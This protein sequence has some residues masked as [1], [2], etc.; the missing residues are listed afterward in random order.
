MRSKHQSRECGSVRVN[1]NSFIISSIQR[2]ETD[3]TPTAQDDVVHELIL[4]RG[5]KF[6]VGST[7]FL[8][9]FFADSYGSASIFFIS[10][11]FQL[12]KVSVW[13]GN[14]MI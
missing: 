5:P 4:K 9:R 12:E 2:S 11:C 13:L 3:A 1:Q 10:T 8:Q 7:P 6:R 14:S